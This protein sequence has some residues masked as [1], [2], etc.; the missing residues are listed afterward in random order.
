MNRIW[1]VNNGNNVAKLR[2]THGESL[3]CDWWIT[4]SK[5]CKNLNTETG[6]WEMNWATELYKQRN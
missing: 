2:E 4:N 3:R 1:I 5:G 6:D